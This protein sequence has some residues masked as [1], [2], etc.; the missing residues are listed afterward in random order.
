[1]KEKLFCEGE[2]K[3]HHGNLYCLYQ[4]EKNVNGF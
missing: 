2:E 4:G 3:L 1:M